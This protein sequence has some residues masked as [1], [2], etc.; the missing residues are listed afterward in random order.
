M[1]DEH[2][3]VVLLIPED[4]G[5]TITRVFRDNISVTGKCQLQEEEDSHL[6]ELVLRG[7]GGVEV[8]CPDDVVVF[9]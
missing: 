4:R 8:Q 1:A 2:G 5:Q 7:V 6:A 9:H 3:S